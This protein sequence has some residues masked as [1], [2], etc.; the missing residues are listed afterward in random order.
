MASFVV[1]YDRCDICNCFVAILFDLRIIKKSLNDRIMGILKKLIRKQKANQITQEERW[2]E[3]M[4]N[5]SGGLLSERQ[6]KQREKD[7]RELIK[8]VDE[9]K[10]WADNGN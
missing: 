6:K 8:T 3:F 2:N 7:I 9:L 1:H 5:C 4:L 10:K